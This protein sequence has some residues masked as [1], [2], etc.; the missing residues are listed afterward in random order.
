[1]SAK[2]TVVVFILICIEIGLL[3]TIIPWIDYWNSNH[4]LILLAER[5]HWPQLISIAR[6]G[7]VRGAVTGLGL[8]NL[9]LAAREVINFK[10]T[11]R[12][13][14]TEWQGEAD[15]KPPGS[16]AVSDNGPADSGSDSTRDTR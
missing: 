7:F 13:L 3:L 15:S 16:T 14:Q 10:Q 4:L 9:M 6:S 8:L 2:I 5:L 11:V 1:M 12:S